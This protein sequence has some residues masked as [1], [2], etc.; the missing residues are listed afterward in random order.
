MCEFQTCGVPLLYATGVLGALGALAAMLEGARR[1]RLGRDRARVSSDRTLAE[2]LRGLCRALGLW[3]VHDDGF[4]GF[5][6]S[7]VVRRFNLQGGMA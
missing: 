7:S 1:A 5:G 4:R 6:R 3:G 2:I